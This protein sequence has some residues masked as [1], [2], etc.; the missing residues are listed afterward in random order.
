MI[1]AKKS[2]G[3]NFLRDENV[4]RK[5]VA[6]LRLSPDD[7][8]VEIGPGSGALTKHLLSETRTV[9]G[10]ELDKRAAELLHDTFGS[11]LALLQDDVL[12][13]D[14]AELARLHKQHLRVVG[15]IPYYI[16][17]EILFRLFEFRT[18]VQDATLMMQRE[19][20]QRLVAKPKTKD[21]GIL[22]VATQL[23][24]QPEILFNVSRN[25]FYPKPNVDSAIVHLAFKQ[26]LPRCN[27][28]LFTSIVR[29]TFGK[30]RKTL[31]NGL[32]YMGFSEQQLDT[33]EFDLQKRPEELTVEDFLRL[34]SLLE[35]FE[36]SIRN[37]KLP[38]RARQ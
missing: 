2:L 34:T 28:L 14:L 16:T 11:A 19:V 21:Y 24:T 33:V 23:H 10:I 20:A 27:I 1:V 9:I 15:N 31:R 3:Q 18:V 30:R 7:M 17:S 4:A 29:S 26:E 8:V 35:P 38:L 22:S 37:L 13:I 36:Q 5:I 6:S 25:S 32:R 12:R